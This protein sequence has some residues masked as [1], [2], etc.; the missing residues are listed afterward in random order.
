MD[1]FRRAFAD[2]IAPV[3]VTDFLH[4]YWE[5]RSLF[6][7]GD[8]GKFAGFGFG[9]ATLRRI[10]ELDPE[11][12][13]K[14][15]YF[16]RDGE[17]A[18]VAITADQA[19]ALFDAGLT[20]CASGLEE[21]H[22]PFGAL[23]VACKT[24]FN[25]AEAFDVS[26]YWSPSGGGFGPHFDRQSVVIVQLEGSKRWRYSPGPLMP[27]PGRN[28]TFTT[29]NRPLAGQVFPW[30]PE[31]LALPNDDEMEERVLTP[32][33]ALYLPAGTVHQTQA[34]GSSLALTLTFFHRTFASLLPGLLD[35]RLGGYPEWRAAIP[36][37]PLEE[38]PTTGLPPAVESF[39]AD[40]ILQLRALADTL[41][42]ADLAHLWRAEV[43][44][45]R[46][47]PHDSPDP[48][49]S[50]AEVRKDDVLAVPA[51]VFCSVAPGADPSCGLH[52]FFAD[53]HLT[54]PVGAQVFI[55]HLARHH[56]FTAEEACSWSGGP[57]G[58]APVR[59]ALETLL[60]VGMLIRAK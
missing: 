59:T 52:V 32:G 17:H 37:V 4:E 54:L 45:Y 48:E 34:G 7:A 3:K 41:E 46:F 16:D 56:R 24:Y 13:M 18:V 55:E 23:A 11:R 35:E 27:A 19:G 26:C 42:P 60:G 40:R 47:V 50:E 10:F 53:R 36:L 6:I 38:A 39:F 20:V 33:D 25:L 8:P 57:L 28:F 2:L 21:D 44:R 58:W 12:G 51:P 49:P 15:Q 31:P 30:L 5:R 14:A 29:A 9:E 43:A 1:R 22:P